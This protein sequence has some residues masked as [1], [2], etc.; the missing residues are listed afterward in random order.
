MRQILKK[1]INKNFF[2]PSWYLIFVNPYFIARRGLY[3][4]IKAFSRNNFYNKKIL[5]VGCGIKP[6]QD[7]FN[8][9]EKYIGIDIRGGGHYDKAKN[10]DQFFDGLNIPFK[11]ESF[12]VVICTQVLEHSSDP[13]KLLKEINRVLKINGQ[14]FLT[15][16]FVWS[17]HEKPFDFNR[18]T[19]FRHEK[20]FKEAGFKINKIESTCGV[21]G[22]C[23]QL[24]SAF[25][26]EKITSENIIIKFSVSFVFCFPIQTVFILLDFL[27]KNNWITLDY[28]VV[29]EK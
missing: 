26:F 5:D 13:F 4:S 15:M 24:I 1:F 12:D 23:G 21:F 8:G 18:F 6:Y 14:L 28:V 2:K 10:A 16:P 9:A 29:A 11:N 25:I 19:S 17:E 3:K 7:L 27:F 22:V 20:I